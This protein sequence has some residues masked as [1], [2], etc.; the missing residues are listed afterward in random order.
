MRFFLLPILL[1][2]VAA[3]TGLP[4]GVSPVRF[5]PA[6]YMGDWYSIARLDHSFERGLTNVRATYALKA[7]GTVSVHNRGFD[8]KRCS[9][10]EIEGTARLQG[11]DDVASLSVSFFPLLSGGYHVIALDTNYQWA[12]VSGPTRGYLWILSRR[13]TLDPKV[14]ARLI[15]KATQLGF[16]TQELVMVDQNKQTC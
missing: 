10:K 11:P 6:R 14:T 2:A 13:P 8:P 3:C 12:M 1:L 16:A 5:E 7:D 4:Q 9:W 15:D